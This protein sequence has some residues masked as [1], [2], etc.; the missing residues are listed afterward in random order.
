V[1]EV[2]LAAI[3]AHREMRVSTDPIAAVTNIAGRPYPR[4]LA[5][6]T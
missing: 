4:T 3:R 5:S 1:I 2:R 6:T